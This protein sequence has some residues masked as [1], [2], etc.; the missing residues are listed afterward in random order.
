MLDPYLELSHHNE[1]ETLS[2]SLILTRSLNPDPYSNQTIL[3]SQPQSPP[4]AIGTRISYI[5]GSMK[6]RRPSFADVSRLMM[7][8]PLMVSRTEAHQTVTTSSS[9]IKPRTLN[10]DS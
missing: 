5:L 8:A 7:T 9:T 4:K 1:L 10:P 2:L 6:R 3:S